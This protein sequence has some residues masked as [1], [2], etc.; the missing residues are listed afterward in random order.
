MAQILTANPRF[1]EQ[2]VFV[3][4]SRQQVPRLREVRACHAP[5]LII[6]PVR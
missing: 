6:A 4:C 2:S 3:T 5:Q 1:P